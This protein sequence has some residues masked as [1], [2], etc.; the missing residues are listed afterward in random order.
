MLRLHHAGARVG[1]RGRIMF[2]EDPL[3]LSSV[4]RVQ[5]T[6]SAPPRRR[7]AAARSAAPSA[8]LTYALTPALASAARDSSLSEPA[9]TSV[10][11]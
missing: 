4:W 3:R 7:R 8:I 5:Q 2:V 11:S 1:I 9:A 6:R 10:P